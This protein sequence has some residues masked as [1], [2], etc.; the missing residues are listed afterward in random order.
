MHFTSL[1]AT[2][3][4]VALASALPTNNHVVLEQR[5]GQ[6]SWTAD[7][8]LKPD[9]RIKLPMRIGLKEKNIELGDEILTQV[10]DPTSEKFGQHLSPEEVSL[11]I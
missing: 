1:A 8:R 2:A 11:D 9:G 10:S 4:V 7:D 3:F 5:S 6:S